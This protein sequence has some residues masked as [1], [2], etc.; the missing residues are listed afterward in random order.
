MAACQRA[1]RPRLFP[2][3]EFFSRRAE[4]RECRTPG[5]SIREIRRKPPLRSSVW[6]SFGIEKARIAGGDDDRFA[7]TLDRG[8]RRDRGRPSCE[9]RQ[10]AGFF[11]PGAAA[12]CRGRDAV[13]PACSPG[14]TALKKMPLVDLDAFLCRAPGSKSPS[15]AIC[16]CV[17]VRPGPVFGLAST[18]EPVSMR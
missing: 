15:S 8:G 14:N 16:T 2:D 3:V 5:S 17:G 9:F 1:R 6:S 7:L 13:F 11:P 4:T 10:Q 18:A 12:A